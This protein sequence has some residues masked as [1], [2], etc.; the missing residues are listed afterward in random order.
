MTNSGDFADLT[1]CHM[2]ALACDRLVEERW[3]L[4]VLAAGRGP[5][6]LPAT[7][8]HVGVTQ[9]R[10]SQHRINSLLR[11]AVRRDDHVDRGLAVFFA[12][13]CSHR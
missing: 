2:W 13:E 6:D 7:S 11:S 12:R 10:Q 3:A 1:D 5:F 4:V 8:G 9:T